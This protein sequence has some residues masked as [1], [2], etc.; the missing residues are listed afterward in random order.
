M[1]KLPQPATWR[2][3]ILRAAPALM[4]ACACVP[5]GAPALPLYSIDIHAFGSA[6]SVL[7]NGCFRLSVSI[8]DPAPG[9]SANGT[10][11][12]Y[13]GFW[14]AAPGAGADEVFFYGFEEC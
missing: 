3:T 10:Y 12:L 7:A 9:Y 6:A 1:A 5:S 4:L 14:A 11:T 13:A 2:H 8:S